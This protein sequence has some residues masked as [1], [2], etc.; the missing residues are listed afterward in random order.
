MSVCDWGLGGGGRALKEIRHILVQYD[1]KHTNKNVLLT[2]MIR[3]SVAENDC[4]SN[5]SV[6]SLSLSCEHQPEKH[7]GGPYDSQEADSRRRRTEGKSGHAVATISWFRGQVNDR[8]FLT[9]GARTV[10]I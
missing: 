4:L 1:N 3:R 5:K 8:P 2:K 9:S 6:Q 7:R 10:Y